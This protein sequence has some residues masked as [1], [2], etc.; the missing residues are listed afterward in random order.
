MLQQAGADW[1]KQEK[2]MHG[3]QGIFRALLVVGHCR[4]KHAGAVRALQ[5]AGRH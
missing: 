3:T 5:S 1:L 4:E 2:Y